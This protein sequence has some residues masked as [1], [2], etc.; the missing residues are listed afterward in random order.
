MKF[1]EI[2]IFFILIAAFSSV[3][4]FAQDT[5]GIRGKVRTTRGDA[6]T[7]VTVTARQNGED[8]KTVASDGNGKFVLEN[9]N[10]K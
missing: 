5:G 9:P 2:S 10:L 8:V 7:G 4:A 6:I 1:V 3:A